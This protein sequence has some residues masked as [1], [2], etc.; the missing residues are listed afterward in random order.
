[1][2]CSLKIR[3]ISRLCGR[4]LY[5]DKKECL[6]IA[7][8]YDIYCSDNGGSTWR[9]DCRLPSTGW[10][11]RAARNRLAARLLRYYV[12]AFRVLDD[13]SRIAVA[14]EG[15]F[16]AESGEQKMTPVFRLTRGSRPLNLA[17]DGPRVIFGEY[18]D[19]YGSS[20]VFVYVSEDYGRSFQ[21]GYRFP[22]G[23]IRH[24]HNVLVDPYQDQYWV[25]VGDFGRQPGIGV[26]SKDMKSLDW[27]CR[28]SQRYRA[29]G[30]VVEKDG[31]VYG[32]D[33]DRDR[34]FILRMDR[35]SGQIEDLREVEGSSL[36]AARFG[37]VRLIS[38]CVE[39]NP[40]CPS[41]ECSLYASQNGTCWQR[42]AIHQKDRYHPTLFQ[43]GTLVLPYAH[44]ESR[45]GMYSGQAV[46]G[47]DDRV[48]LIDFHESEES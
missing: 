6:Y 24:V 14:R 33:S 43:F 31:L 28:G 46:E 1:M 48:A 17:V 4:A 9:L 29:V 10:K 13:G 39:P 34:N 8:S 5:I 21:V 35:Q 26:L 22:R 44:H 2:T 27:I 23:D 16:R 30:A 20:E 40:K 36:Y 42:V 25:F 12:A 19:G 38:T 45:R 11:S 41:R 3:E 47:M 18:G 7:R 37:P 32:T 15:I